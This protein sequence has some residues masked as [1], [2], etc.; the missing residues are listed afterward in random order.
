MYIK[1]INQKLSI[2]EIRMDGIKYDPL[3]RLFQWDL[4]QSTIYSIIIIIWNNHKSNLG[5][6]VLNQFVI[7]TT[8]L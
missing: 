1:C 8:L 2:V 7:N 4:F 5:T 3:F 6:Y